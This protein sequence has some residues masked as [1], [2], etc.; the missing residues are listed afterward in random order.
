MFEPSARFVETCLQTTN[1]PNFTI[2][3][4]VVSK[5]YEVACKQN[6]VTDLNQSFP[7]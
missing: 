5:D 6:L 2:Y 7:N 1:S 3:C 4:K